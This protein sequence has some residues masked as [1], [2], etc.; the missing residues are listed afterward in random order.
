MRSSSPPSSSPSLCGLIDAIRHPH[1]RRGL[2]WSTSGS[3]S[4]SASQLAYRAPP[5]SR[6][7]PGPR[8]SPGSIG[9]ALW[10]AFD[11]YRSGSPGSDAPWSSH[12]PEIPGDTSPVTLTPPRDPL[13]RAPRRRRRGRGRGR[14]S[15]STC[16]R[17]TGC[18]IAAIVAMKPGLDRIRAGRPNNASPETIIGA[19][20][21]ALFLLTIDTKDRAARRR[22]RHP[23]VPS[24]LSIRGLNYALY[25]AAIAAMFRPHRD[26][27]AASVRLGRR[28][29]ARAVHASLGLELRARAHGAADLVALS[30]PCRCT[31]CRAHRQGSMPRP[32]RCSSWRLPGRASIRSTERHSRPQ[33]RLRRTRSQAG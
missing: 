24:R 30:R 13:R 27:P 17:R 6:R 1:V 25:C 9:S 15:G 12:F 11:S 18:P 33:R 2:R 5:T 31:G 16:R 7:R 10:I 3:S 14:R 22:H 32:A 8:R 23:R 26:G 19:A 4:P 21:A 20:A 28:G 29:A